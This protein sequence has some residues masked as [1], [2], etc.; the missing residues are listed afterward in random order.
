MLLSS[1][2]GALA[3]GQDLATPLHQTSQAIPI[4]SPRRE[5]SAE[6]KQVQSETLNR[7]FTADVEV[8]GNTWHLLAT[9]PGAVIHDIAFPTAKIGYA[10]AELGQVW[11]TTDG[12]NHWTE[13][14]SASQSDYFYGVDALSTEDVIISGFYDSTQ[15]YGVYRWSHDGGK[16]WTDDLSFGP[17]WMQRV[18]YANSKDGIIME[19]P[20]SNSVTESE[21]TVDG[22]GQLSNWTSSVANPSGGWFDFQFSLLGNLHARSSGINYCT[23]LNGGEKWACGNSVDSVF[24]GPVFFL[25]DKYGWV[26]GGEISPNVEGWLHLTTDGGKSWSG[27]TLDGPWPI[28]SILFLTDKTGWATGGNVYSNVGGMYFTSDGGNTWTVDATTNSE[29]GACAQ[30]AIAGGHHQIWCAGFNSSNGFESVI[31]STTF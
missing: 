22:G 17:A 11:K 19:F 2:L 8:P 13:V 15:T 10:A 16:T 23:S 14:L 7:R 26:G 12:G 24:D 29:M 1:L 18:R 21:Y 6:R 31:Y 3:V 27:R 4:T 9:L 30:H 5:L 25:N 20:G 28:R